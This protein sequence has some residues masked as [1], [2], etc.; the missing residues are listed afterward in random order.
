MF[1]PQVL[2]DERVLGPHIVE[3]CHLRERP[4][5]GVGRRSRLPISEQSRYHNEILLG[6][7]HMVFANEPL[8]VGD[9]FGTLAR[10]SSFSSEGSHIRKTTTDR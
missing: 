8:V 4:D 7:Q 9:G 3:E 1:D 10:A 2:G 5:V 6:V